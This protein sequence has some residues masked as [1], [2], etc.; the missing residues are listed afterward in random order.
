MSASKDVIRITSFFFFLRLKAKNESITI[1]LSSK[2]LRVTL[3]VRK[4]FLSATIINCMLLSWSQK[5]LIALWES[6]SW[7]ALQKL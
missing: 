3:E 6:G 7:Q 2:S 4:D 1:S 5:C